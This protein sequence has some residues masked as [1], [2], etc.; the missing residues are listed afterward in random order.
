MIDPTNVTNFSLNHQ[1]LEEHLI[2]WI[3]AAGHNGVST[4]KGVEKFLCA[5][6]EMLWEEPAFYPRYPFSDIRLVIDNCGLEELQDMLRKSGLGC[7]KIKSRT[8]DQLVHADMDLHECT[9]EDLEAIKGIGPK[10]ARCFLLHSRPN[11]RLA[12]LDTHVRKYMRSKGIDIPNGSLSRKKYL[13]YEEKWLE[14]C[15]EEGKEPHEL[16]LEVWNLYQVSKPSRKLTTLVYAL[17]EGVHV[18]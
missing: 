12:G 16:D 18:N 3:F 9:L 7:W 14:L 17:S 10:T 2:W 11:Q 4:A 15:D 1:E 13:H 8:L 6:E 5:A